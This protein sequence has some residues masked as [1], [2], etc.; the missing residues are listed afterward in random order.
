[1]KIK[2]N[3]LV[4]IQLAL[5]SLDNIK[6]SFHVAYDILKF[7][8]SVE[9]A[10]VLYKEKHQALFDKYLEIDEN[11]RYI[12]VSECEFRLKDNIDTLQMSREFGELDST[13]IEVPDLSIPKSALENQEITPLN[14]SHLSDFIKED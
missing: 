12:Q 2:L 6:F 11:G 8:R 3:R 14:L 13:E 1:M 9:D 7:S 5:K 10:L 4:D